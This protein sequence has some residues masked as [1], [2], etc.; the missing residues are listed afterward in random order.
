MDIN[1]EVNPR[2]ED[3]LFDWNQKFQFL[4]GGY[5]SSKSYH[6]ALKIILKLLS[7]KR[8]AL[9]IREVY[10]THKDSTFSLFTEIIEDLGLLDESSRKKVAKGKIRPKES[11]YELRFSNGSKIIFK[12]MDKPAKLKS[13][14]NVSLIW[15]E[16][17]S[18][19]KYE[20]FKELIGRLRH[21]KLKLHMI[22]STNPIGED[23]WTYLHF[24]KDDE[25]DRFVLDDN[26]LYQKG[27]VV[28]GD[29]YY[30]HS[31]ADD[32][33]FLP[34]SYIEQLDELA[35]Y[36]PDLH[37]VARL[38][39]YG[40][41]GKRVLPQFQVKSHEEVM[42]AIDE[43]DKPLFKN[44][45]DFGFVESYN[46]L[47]RMAIDH[48]NKYLYIFEQYYKR[49]MTD[50]ELVEDLDP[51]KK[52]MIKADSAEP[53]T[54]AYF[55][56]RRFRIMGAKKGPGSRLQNTKKVKRFKKIICSD[57]CPDVIRELKNLT[58]AKD[59]KGKIIEDEF[60]IDPHTFSAIWYGLDDYE[61][62]SIKGH[63]ARRKTG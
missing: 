12:G 63:N 46:A 28:V 23:N 47:V 60:N 43:I 10:D 54:I 44:G 45:L 33:L 48:E 17:C 50:P 15:L 9:V 53:K 31:T 26:E 25:N 1:K 36:D 52:I 40:V 49:G 41:N 7:E 42:R 24:F 61:V 51:Y 39:R 11:P 57:A 38:G 3:F 22:L 35:E 37:R 6:V 29:T 4:M 5:G 20:G 55:R 13:I 2:F 62:A 8:K 30:H 19:V 18:E 32:N 56:Q 58:F 21:P 59:K 16:E 27:T 14:N 34:D